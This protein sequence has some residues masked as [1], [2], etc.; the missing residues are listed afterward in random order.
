MTTA[1]LF[2]ALAGFAMSIL[3]GVIFFLLIQTGIKYGWKKAIPIALGVIAGDIIYIILS[4]NVS[5]ALQD[6]LVINKTSVG[7]AGSFAL[8]VFG[9]AQI[10][11]KREQESDFEKERGRFS[12]TR[13]FFIKPFIINLLNPG[14]ALIWLGLY[15]NPPA[16]QFDTSEKYAFAAGALGAIFLTEVVIAAAAQKLKSFTTPRILNIA[17]I[18]LGLVF[19]ALGGKLMVETVW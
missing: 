19:I 2:G 1:L 9:A 13:D 15:S 14:N 8:F 7:V 6:F 10:F 3:L 5:N 12:N 11:K 16:S 17:D 18:V 4:L